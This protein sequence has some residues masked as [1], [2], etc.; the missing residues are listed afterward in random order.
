MGRGV[1]ESGT[2]WPG[3]KNGPDE[4]TR[5]EMVLARAVPEPLGRI[6]NAD[7]DYIVN[8][9]QWCIFRCLFVSYI[10][11]QQNRVGY[12]SPCRARAGEPENSNLIFSA[13][14]G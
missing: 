14:R 2:R 1:P 13:S 9:F 6:R 7:S 11:K 8:V 4:M 5:Y 10:S 3:R 12:E